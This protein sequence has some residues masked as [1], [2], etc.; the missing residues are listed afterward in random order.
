MSTLARPN[1]F[2]PRVHR[3]RSGLY[4][5]A[6]AAASYLNLSTWSPTNFYDF[7]KTDTI[8][9]SGGAV[10]S[11]LDRVTGVTTIT[12]SNASFKP[13]TGTR[14]INGHNVLDFA[15]DILSAAL[16]ANFTTGSIIAV[17]E[18]DTVAAR[19]TISGS[20]A[21]SGFALYSDTGPSKFRVVKQNIAGVGFYDTATTSSAT[22]Y[23]VGV[24]F[25]DAANGNDLYWNING[26]T[27]TDS[28]HGQTLAGAGTTEFGAG[29]ASGELFDGK[30]GMLA[31]WRPGISTANLDAAC[32]ATKTWWGI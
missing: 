19:G 5:A 1:A 16:T 4:V 22:P 21:N 28:A 10:S 27:E 26:V 13:T 29:V 14:N 11:V 24:T 2:S 3:R 20:S 7:S 8:T 32:A 18:M 31:V 23:V 9:H 12:Q 30:I 17:V 25:R 15:G 6:S